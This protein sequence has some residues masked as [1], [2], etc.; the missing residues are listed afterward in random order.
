MNITCLVRMSTH[1]LAILAR[2]RGMASP[3]GTGFPSK[4]K[5]SSNRFRARWKRKES[6]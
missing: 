5:L 6:L 4:F 1:G 3:F 2:Q